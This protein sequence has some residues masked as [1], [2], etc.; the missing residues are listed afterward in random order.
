MMAEL[1]QELVRKKNPTVNFEIRNP[2]CLWVT[3]QS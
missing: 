1:A 2:C 3:G